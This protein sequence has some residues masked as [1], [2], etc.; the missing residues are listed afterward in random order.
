MYPTTPEVFHSG[1]DVEFHWTDPETGN[2]YPGEARIKHMHYE[3]GVLAGY[4]LDKI[5]FPESR[6][7]EE[8]FHARSNAGDFIVPLSAVVRHLASQPS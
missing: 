2:T 1:Q 3:D 8:F 6:V 4:A 7:E 5:S